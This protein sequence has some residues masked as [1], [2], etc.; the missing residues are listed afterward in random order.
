M[1]HIP[2]ICPSP[3][4]VQ[5]KHASTSPQIEIW[6]GVECTY[7]RVG[8]VYFDQIALSGH[9]VRLDD[10]DRFAELG[11]RTLRYGLVWERHDVDPSWRW[12]DARMRDL[13]VAGID[14]ILG[15]VHHGSGPRHTSLLDPLFPE[16]LAAYAGQVAARYPHV[17]AYT[18]VNE[19]HTTARFSGLYGVWYPHHHSRESYLRALLNETKATVLSMRAVR[20]VRP[21]AKLVQTEDVG[22]I[23]STSRLSSLQRVL[24]ERR[25]LGFD[26]LCG[27]V[28]PSHPLFQYLRQAGIAER[29]I[30]WF[31]E[32]PC[33]PD[34]IGVNYYLT[35]DRFLDER[36]D[37]YPGDRGSAEGPI[38]D[39]EAVRVCPEGIAGFEALLTEAW[40]RY[41]IPVAI[42]EVHLGSD[43]V[44]DQIRWAAEAWLGAQAARNAGVDCRAMTFWALLGSY[45]WDSLVRHD[46]GH[47]EAGLFDVRGGVPVRTELADFAEQLI[48]GKLPE[49]PALDVQGWW[50]QPSRL[51]V[52]DPYVEDERRAA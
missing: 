8:D 19:P 49:H 44:A 13:A 46:N 50:H 1:S 51:W 48:T 22:V 21:D 6:G 23:R 4:P 34:V 39:I 45:F 38:V 43:N 7:N 15:L 5:H 33:P 37:R 28:W 42:T 17:N 27:R 41:R 26:L 30:L 11:I 47:Y 31:T 3:A 25:W 10:L 18:P 32:N 14:P 36:V 12:A 52:P 20:R 9:E 35:S 2:T 24:D 40:E 16:K 29:E